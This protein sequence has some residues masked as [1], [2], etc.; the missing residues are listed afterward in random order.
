MIPHIY[1]DATFVIV[2]VETDICDNTTCDGAIC[3]DV[4]GKQ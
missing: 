3:D 2:T 4:M 1:D